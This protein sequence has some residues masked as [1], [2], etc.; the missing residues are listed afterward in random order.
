M[1]FYNPFVPHVVS[2]NDKYAVRKFSLIKVNYIYFDADDDD[3]WLITE[4]IKRY[5]LFDNLK[6]AIE[7]RDKLTKKPKKPEKPIIKHIDC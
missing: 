3:F 5:C 6:D 4:N 2:Y 7:F 1:K